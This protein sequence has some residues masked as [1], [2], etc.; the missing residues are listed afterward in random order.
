MCIWP[1]DW[2]SE[3][4]VCEHMCDVRTSLEHVQVRHRGVYRDVNNGVS[5]KVC[6]WLS[7]EGKAFS[8]RKT[9]LKYRC[10]QAPTLPPPPPRLS[11]WKLLLY[12]VVPSSPPPP[13]PPQPSFSSLPPS[14]SPL[15]RWSQLGQGPYP[16]PSSLTLD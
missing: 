9:V 10:A 5:V 3:T 4:S 2:L 15:S 11:S 12:K 14:P 8:R 7:V 1:F 13:L 16:P 6:P